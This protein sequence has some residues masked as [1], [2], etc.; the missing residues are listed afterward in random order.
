[1]LPKVTES[2]TQ[3]EKERKREGETEPNVCGVMCACVEFV[4]KPKLYFMRLILL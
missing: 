3:R 4:T 2:T 1:M